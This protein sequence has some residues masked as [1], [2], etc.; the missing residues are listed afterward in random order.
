MAWRNTAAAETLREQ[1]NKR[2]PGRDKRSDGTIGDTAHAA[3]KSDH[4]PDSRG[5]VHAIDIDAD[6]DPN[7][8]RAA[9]R[10][11]TD[12][13]NYARS[14]KPGSDRI[15]Y[16]V[17]NNRIASGTYADQFWTWR[18][19]AWGHEHHIHVSF[20]TA[21]ER[22]GSAFPLP[23]FATARPLPVVSWSKLRAGKPASPDVERV[24]R[25]LNR[26]MP[27]RTPLVVDGK[28]GRKT[29]RRWG[30]AVVKSGGKRGV[31]LL[32]F[33]ADLYGKFRAAP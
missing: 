3:R 27:R 22:D 2:W 31:H 10:L 13:I 16:V 28:W 9:E 30:L 26:Y 19:G 8:R 11:A 1:V 32:R 21:A 12:L 17:Y 29:S 24:Q 7:D 4:N 23:V 6:L 25:A 18:P 20:T 15:K 33:F 5:W 14:G